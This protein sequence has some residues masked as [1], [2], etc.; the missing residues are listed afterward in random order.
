MMLVSVNL[1]SL[2]LVLSMVFL[3][4]LMMYLVY[5]AIKHYTSLGFA[6]PEAFNAWWFVSW[7]VLLILR[8]MM[9]C[10][11]L[12]GSMMISLVRFI[13]LNKFS[14]LRQEARNT[15]SQNAFTKLSGPDSGLTNPFG[16]TPEGKAEF[17]KILASGVERE[18]VLLGPNVTQSQFNDVFD[19]PNL[20]QTILN[21]EE[22]L[23]KDSFSNKI[24]Q[25]FEW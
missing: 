2:L 25:S 7:W 17:D 1:M 9:H 16:D 22:N 12:L 19:N 4:L 18:N 23:R 6:A 24:N 8:S 21:D 15:L 3:E 11:M 5:Q 10:W 13:L 14:I 20:G